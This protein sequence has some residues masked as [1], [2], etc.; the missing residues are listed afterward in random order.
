MV[1]HLSNVK[2]HGCLTLLILPFALTALTFGS[3][4]Y[5]Y[6]PKV[7]AVRINGRINKVKQP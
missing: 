2:A 5:C 3:C 6:E 7:K 4:W 1:T